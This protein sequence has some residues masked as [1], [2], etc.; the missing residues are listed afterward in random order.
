MWDRTSGLFEGVF[1]A[2]PQPF[3]IWFPKW[4]KLFFF[5]L[6]N[7]FTHYAPIDLRPDLKKRK[8]SIIK[9]ARHL[10]FDPETGEV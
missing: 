6:S 8:R 3:E 1:V 7:H 10:G 5:V 4:K 9:E 2:M